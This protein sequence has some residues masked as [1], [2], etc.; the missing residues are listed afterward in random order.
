MIREVSSSNSTISE[1]ITSSVIPLIDSN[2]SSEFVSP[3]ITFKSNVTQATYRDSNIDAL[4]LRPR[5]ELTDKRDRFNKTFLNPDGTTSVQSAVYSLHY[6][7][8][9]AWK[10]INTT[11]RQD[12]SDGKSTY[13]MLAN[14]FNV[15]LNNQSSKQA[16]TFS[17]SDQSVTYRAVG[18]RNV[19]GSVYENTVFFNKEGW[20]CMGMGI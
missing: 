10:E 20:N 8:K 17:V 14:R 7:D 1:E 12:R 9:R 4:K 11:L 6:L 15:R 18:M 13:S 16:V 3:S 19:T 2:S 5:T